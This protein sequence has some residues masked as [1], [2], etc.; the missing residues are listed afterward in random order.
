ME[1]SREVANSSSTSIPQQARHEWPTNRERLEWR[2]WEDER[3]VE[4]LEN[5]E[6]LEAVA[7]DCHRTLGAVQK[8]FERLMSCPIT[9]VDQKLRSRL[10]QQRIKRR[11]ASEQDIEQLL[12][13]NRDDLNRRAHEA[14]EQIGGMV[15]LLLAI[16]LAA[17]HTSEAEVRRF[18]AGEIDEHQ[19]ASDLAARII[20]KAQRIR[21]ARLRA[22]EL[23]SPKRRFL[24]IFLGRCE[25][26][27]R[28]PM[29]VP[30]DDGGFIGDQAQRC[31]ELLDQISAAECGDHGGMPILAIIGQGS[32]ATVIR[33]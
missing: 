14:L 29:A 15:G 28:P 2:G 3:L 5:G 19:H 17:G 4:A 25:Q 9:Q 7:A 30:L 32:S 26:P 1:S 23:R 12:V 22:Q 27:A 21:E 11:R 10:L 13:A 6:T 24:G 16:E 20:S 33:G 18:V 31:R 8:H